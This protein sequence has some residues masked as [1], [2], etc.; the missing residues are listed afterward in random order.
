MAD[1]IARRHHFVPEFL[2]NK[3]A[4]ENEVHGYFCDER[5]AILRCKRRGAKAFCHKMDLWTLKASRWK[6]D[7]IETRFFG[8]IDDK[9][10]KVQAVLQ[11]SGPDS[12]TSEQRSDFARLLLSLDIRRPSIVEKVRDRSKKYADGLNHDPMILDGKEKLGLPDKPSKLYEQLT[13]VSLED[14]A[15][16]GIQKLVD[17]HE[18]GEIL[19]NAH[20][21]VVRLGPSDGTLVLSDRPLIRVGD[22]DHPRAGWILPMSPNTAFVAVNHYANL[23]Q[24]KKLSPQ[25]FAKETNISSVRQTDHYV[26]AIDKSHTN[27]IGKHF[28]RPSD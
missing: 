26:F 17:N 19:I 11:T 8:A 6:P 4:I 1:G 24:I 28:S 18:V 9:G 3:W 13:G 2:L 10:A 5:K 20:W 16:I 14:V 22:F 25:R 12:L 27:W 21:H 7:A 23:T 15:L